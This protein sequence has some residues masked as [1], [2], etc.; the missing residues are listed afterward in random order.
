MIL[1][2]LRKQNFKNIEKRILTNKKNKT[3]TETN[4]S[5][6]VTT[7]LLPIITQS[8]ILSQKY[9]I[10][11]T[12]P[13]YMGSNGMNKK[14]SD[15]LKNH[16]PDSKRD[17]FTSFIERG[18]NLIK[19]NMFNSM[20]TMQSWM[21]LSSFEKLRHKITN[22]YIISNLLHMENMVMGIAFGTS[23]TVFR[24]IQNSKFKGTFNQIKLN[25]L[26]EEKI[27]IEFP[28]QKNYNIV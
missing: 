8:K 14:L 17:L 4:L 10:V 12:N 26:N 7:K 1:I 2:N 11:V 9:E 24:K 22:D 15:F 19:D 23:A 13:P 3:L 21:F 6:K 16:F 20:V 28:I 27:P 18:L 25:D 5:K